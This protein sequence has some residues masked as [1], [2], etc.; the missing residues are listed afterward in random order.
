MLLG[1]SA[2]RQEQVGGGDKG[3]VPVPAGERAALE[4]VESEGRLQLAVV[5]LDVPPQ[6]RDAGRITAG[7]V[8]GQGRVCST[9]P[10]RSRP[11][12]AGR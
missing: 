3:D 7:D 6:C 10:A 5:V 8:G 1:R 11:R 4:V 2:A 9:R 12:A